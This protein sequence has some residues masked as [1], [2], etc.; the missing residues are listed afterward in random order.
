M[1]NESG[2]NMKNEIRKTM[3]KI[4]NNMTQ[5]EV[6]N[7]SVLAA[8][9]FLE[10]DFYKNAKC[11]MLYKR[12]GN[13]T[14]TDIIIKQALSDNK[15]LVFPVTE[16]KNGKITPYYADG[17]TEFNIGGFSVIEPKNS[18]EANP[19]DIEVILI[20]GIAFDAFG[21][22]V[23]FGKGCYDMFL[24]KTKAVKIGFCFDFQL[25]DKIPA[26]VHDINMDYVITDKGIINCQK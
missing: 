20:P 8:G 19:V 15:K 16:E 12:L 14:D 10:S 3:K 11:I 2:D 13:E 5:E 21:A 17:N 26:S 18:V 24:P 9:F 6:L 23:G 1:Y 22:R 4:R 25:A 7:K